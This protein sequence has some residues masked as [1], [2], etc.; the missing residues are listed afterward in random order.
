MKATPAIRF[1]LIFTGSYLVLNLLYG[2]YIESQYPLPDALTT[3]V[4]KQVGAITNFLGRST[5]VSIHPVKPTLS[6]KEG[7]DTV[8]NVYEGCNGVNVSIVFLSFIVAF[9]GRIRQMSW[10]LPVALMLIHGVNLARL[11]VLYFLSVSGSRYF[12]Y[13]H[14]YLF[15]AFIFAFVFLLWWAWIRLSRKS[16]DHHQ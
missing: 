5:E 15:T 8:V 2:L 12:H 4:S 13:F 10:F 1:L 14:K 3:S 16:I 11:L 7:D 6:L 9:G